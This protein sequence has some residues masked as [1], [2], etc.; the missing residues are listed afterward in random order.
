MKSKIYTLTALLLLTVS[1]MNI[2]AFATI[3]TIQSGNFFFNP[4]SLNV[5]VGDTVKW[6]N[7]AG[8]HT[9][10][11]STIPAGAATWDAP[12]NSTTPTFSYKVTVEGIY[13]YVCTPHVAMG[14]VGSFTATIPANT[15][16]VTPGNQ[17]V[18]AAAGSTSFNVSSNT[19]W[20]ASC[21]MSW[22]TCT[23]SGTG[24]GT[25]TANFTQNTSTAQRVATITIS[26]SGVSSQTV[27][28][29][30][31]GAAP[32]LNVTPPSQ[33][34]AASAGSTNFTV[35]SNS[36]WTVSSNQSWCTATPSGTGDGTITATYQANTLNTSR[37]ATLTVTVSG[38]PS[39]TVT[40][41]QDA[42]SVGVGEQ[43]AAAFVIYPNPVVSQVNIA[44]ESLKNTETEVS[45]YNI[46]SNKVLGPVKL[47]GSPSSIDLGAL[48]EGVYF[49]RI[50]S[51]SNSPVKKIVKIR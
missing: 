9:T 16:A 11:S 27:T 49:I 1:A 12:L 24:N 50:G 37:S 33:S 46:N 21:N 20:T 26:A 17:N 8:S 18:G 14:M 43:D 6:V 38:L 30:Q 48:P 40:V 25:I 29:T 19:N 35:S 51:E 5:L 2:N 36:S 10:T 32:A 23:P 7:I 42:S 41:Q 31:A 34:V 13:N 44:G 45:I 3:H 47:S 22:C 28:V 15:L 4:S 39:Q